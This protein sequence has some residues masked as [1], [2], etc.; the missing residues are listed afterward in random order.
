MA[1]WRTCP[2]CNGCGERVTV[3]V[4]HDSKGNEIVQ[5]VAVYCSSCGGDGVVE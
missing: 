1:E 2:D 4:T 5:Q 3:L